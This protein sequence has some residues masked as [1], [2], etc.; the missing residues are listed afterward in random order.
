MNQYFVIDKHSMKAQSVIT[1]SV[2]PK[3]NLDVLFIEK[4]QDLNIQFIHNDYSLKD[5]QIIEMPK[6]AI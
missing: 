3:E 1:V 4:P 2:T 5:G 6:E